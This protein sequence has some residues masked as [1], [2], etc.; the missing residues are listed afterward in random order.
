[1]QTLEE[2]NRLLV[3]ISPHSKAWKL[4]QMTLSRVKI[5]IEDIYYDHVL[6]P[7]LRRALQMHNTAYERCIMCILWVIGRGMSPDVQLNQEAPPHVS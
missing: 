7:Q 6:Q 1:M 4:V 2:I 3:Y 5:V